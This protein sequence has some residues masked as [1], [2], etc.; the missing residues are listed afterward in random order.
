MRLILIRLI[1]VV[2]YLLVAYILFISI[3]SLLPIDRFFNYT[4]EISN[5]IQDGTYYQADDDQQIY[6][7]RVIKSKGLIYHSSTNDASIIVSS[8]NLLHHSIPN[9]PS[10]KVVTKDG[11]TEVITNGGGAT[12][13]LFRTT[14]HYDFSNL[15]DG[16][17]SLTLYSNR[18]GESFSFTY[19]IGDQHE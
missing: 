16:I 17:E 2:E 13:N 1:T 18:Y 6:F 4:K 5:A 19:K 12:S 15:P 10:L 14:G 11:E 9:R 3:T 8:H 7:D